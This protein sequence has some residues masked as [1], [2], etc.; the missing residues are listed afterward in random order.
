MV[1]NL[2][3][4]ELRPAVRTRALKAMRDAERQVGLRKT[5]RQTVA[6]MR[7]L[8]FN[9]DG[10]NDLTGTLEHLRASTAQAIYTQ[11]ERQLAIGRA[12]NASMNGA[13]R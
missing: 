13:H 6:G 2:T 1:G 4:D 7:P 10:S 8:R 12:I 11:A 3:Y 9:E 5:T